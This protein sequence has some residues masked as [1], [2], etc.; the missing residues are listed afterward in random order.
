VTPPKGLQAPGRKFWRA[1]VAEFDLAGPH[2]RALL[3]MAARELDLIARLDGALVGAPLQVDTPAHGLV[4]NRLLA[5]V[6]AHRSAFR[7]LLRELRLPAEPAA[8]ATDVV[9][10]IGSGRSRSH[11]PRAVS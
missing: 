4:A 3:E 7:L 5:E 2:E 8:P 10:P 9:R 11:R 6:A 1:I